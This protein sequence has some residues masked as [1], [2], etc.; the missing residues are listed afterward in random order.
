[1]YRVQDSNSQDDDFQISIIRSA[2]QLRHA[3][4]EK[5]IVSAVHQVETM[6]RVQD[7]ES[8]GHYLYKCPLFVSAQLL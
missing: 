6:C 4:F 2:Q 3:H 7:L 1:M 5:K 8:P